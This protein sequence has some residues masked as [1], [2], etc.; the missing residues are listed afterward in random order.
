[1]RKEF[2]MVLKPL[3]LKLVLKMLTSK[4]NSA[5]LNILCKMGDENC[6]RLLY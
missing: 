2:S 3:E 4:R 1:M 6:S 5:A